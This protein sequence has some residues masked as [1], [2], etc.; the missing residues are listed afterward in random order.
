MKEFMGE[1]FLLNSEIAKKLYFDYAKEMPIFDYH[2]HLNSAQIASNKSFDNISE[3]WLGGDHYKWRA[4]R[5]NGLNERQEDPYQQFLTWA[6]TMPSLIGNPLYSWTHLELQRY[7]GIKEPLNEKNAKAIYEKTNAML[8]QDSSLCVFEIFKKFNVATVGTTD[9]PADDLKF[10]IALKSLTPTK[11]IPSFRPDKALNIDAEGFSD[12][13]KKLGQVANIKINTLDALKEALIKRLDFFIT[14]GCKSTD[15]GLAYPPFI[16]EDSKKI[17]GYFE[18][19]LKGEQISKAEAEAYRTNLLVY[20]G[21]QYSERNIVMQLHL[22]V[23]RNTN[24]RMYNLYGP[25]TGY[26]AVYDAPIAKNLATLLNEMEKTNQLPKTIV[27][28]LNPKDYYS[29][30][31]IIG[32]FQDSKTPGKMQL[33]S[34]WWFCDHKDGIEYQLSTLSDIGLLSKFVGMIT[35]SRSFLSYP[36]HEYF[37]RVLCNF[38]GKWVENGEVPNDIELLGKIIQDICYNNAK[39]YFG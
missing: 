1:D 10:H 19:A 16:K 31:S 36:R 33:G 27:Y 12:Y 18:R 29:I 14:M 22:N 15:Q 17:E 5:A 26:D 39:R 21:K 9:D 8:K 32:S 30:A 37:R 13:I 2:C 34:G 38:V 7:F 20:L 6:K 35:D 4:I 23:I 3:L 25:D 24:T 11:V 28:S